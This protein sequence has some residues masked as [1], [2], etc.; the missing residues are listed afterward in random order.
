MA[1]LYE[2]PSFVQHF[3]KL[4][5]DHLYH[6]TG[7][8]GLLGIVES[9]ELWATKIQYMND[10]TEFGRALAIARQE[11]ETF[12][13]GTEIRSEKAAGENYSILFRASMISTSSPYA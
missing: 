11:L 1:N 6:Y 4:P 13:N 2:P 3:Q 12:M 10:A 7:Q 9:A 8:I 5:P